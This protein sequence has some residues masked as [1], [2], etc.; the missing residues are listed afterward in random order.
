MVYPLVSSNMA[1]WK[2]PERFMEV[3]IARNITELSMVHGFQQAMFDW[4]VV[5]TR[6]KN[7]SQLE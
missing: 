1:G 7:I 6:L 5:S 4:L 3:S 2:I